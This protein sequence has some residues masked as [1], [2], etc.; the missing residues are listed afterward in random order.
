MIGFAGASHPALA[1]EGDLDDA[2][3]RRLTGTVPIESPRVRLVMPPA[4]GNGY[5]VPLVLDVDSPMTDADHVRQVRVFAPKNPIVLV[6]GFGFTPASGQAHVSTRIRLAEPQTVF[7]V[8]EMS[9]GTTLMART[10]VKVDTNG[11][12]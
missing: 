11:C 6:A 1:D 3:L 4:F 12:A 8:A 9:D 2:L 5:T 10:W 7:A